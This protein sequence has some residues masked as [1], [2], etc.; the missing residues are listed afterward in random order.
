M[1]VAI[2]I[3]ASLHL[4]KD[5]FNKRFAILLAEKYPEHEF[6][7]II[8]EKKSSPKALPL[9]V[10][11]IQMGPVIKSRLMA[12][13][14]YDIRLPKLLKKENIDAIITAGDIFSQNT[15][16]SQICLLH[17]AENLKPGFQKF[18]RRRQQQSSDVNLCPVMISDRATHAFPDI[19]MT[20]LRQGSVFTQSRKE[21]K[22][23]IINKI[24]AEEN[25]YFIFLSNGAQDPHLI[26]VM[27]AFSIFK[28]WQ[29]SS[30]KLVMITDTGR[31]PEI[32]NLRNYKY[33]EDVILPEISFESEIGQWIK[34]A[35]A[36][37]S[38]GGK[39]EQDPVLGLLKSEVPVIT[40]YAPITSLFW[41]DAVLY[42][43]V[44]EKELSERMM[45]LYKDDSLRNEL[46][47]RA[48]NIS[49][50]HDWESFCEDLAK[51]FS[52]IIV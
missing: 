30:L 9:N 37:I 26:T 11:L 40:R 25:G 39:A 6:F 18:C 7:F 43:H 36:A 41:G 50:R 17:A 32:E 33:R 44:E 38:F 42:S 49:Q 24:S 2:H 1:K 8:D 13:Y 22:T 4:Y 5:S 34:S 10:R 19:A 15:A 21:E 28:K 3:N 47:K 46:K 23:H 31:I 14:W 16:I 52:G 51:L 20:Y 12:K 27:K 29:R 45:T 48:L 35:F